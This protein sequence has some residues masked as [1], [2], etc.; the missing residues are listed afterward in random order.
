MSNMV[1]NVIHKPISLASD[2]AHLC[3]EWQRRKWAG[4]RPIPCE[5]GSSGSIMGS[6]RA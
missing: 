5:V 1:I 3:S 4:N 2:S 6:E